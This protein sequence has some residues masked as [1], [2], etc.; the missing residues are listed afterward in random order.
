VIV[1]TATHSADPVAPSAAAARA[2]GA[3]ALPPGAQALPP[4]EM[5][6]A[7]ILRPLG[8]QVVVVIGASSGIGRETAQR[9]AARGARLVLGARELAGLEAVVAEC[10][11]AGADV[12]P[13]A[14][15][16]SRFADVEAVAALAVSRFGRI[17]TWVQLA[18]VAVWSPFLDMTAEE[19]RQVVEVNLIGAANGAKVALPHLLA[20][21]GGALIEVS[22]VEAEVPVADQTAYA[23]SKHGMAGFLRALRMEVQDDRLPIAVTQILPSS[24]DTPFF[25][26]ART[27]LGVQPAPVGPVYDPSLVADAIVHAAEH[28]S[29]D[30]RIGGAGIVMAALYKLAPGLTGNVL[31][32][33]TRRQQRSDI[34]K[35]AVAPDNLMRPVGGPGAVRGSGT[36][37]RFSVATWAQLHP[38]VVW[39]AAAGGLTVLVASRLRR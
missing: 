18:G 20:A 29:G 22:S 8:E 13:V 9:L 28:P 5:R 1:V 23:A 15:D 16:V 32:R 39:T 34:P 33:V 37:R 17:D 10:R 38:R 30:L 7:P 31:R 36:G 12:E 26:N 3:Q 27:R 24:I 35:S 21:G 25:A 19:F 4:S 11:A 6:G 2:T 14:V